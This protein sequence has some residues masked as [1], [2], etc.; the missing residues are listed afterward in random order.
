MKQSGLHP[1]GRAG[2]GVRA[3]YRAGLALAALPDGRKTG[4]GDGCFLAGHLLPLAISPHVTISM[5]PAALG[6]QQEQ[7]TGL[8]TL[9]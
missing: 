1:L 6:V 9:V 5:G 7:S 3:G 4:S 2:A 8:Y